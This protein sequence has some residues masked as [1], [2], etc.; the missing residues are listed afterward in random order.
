M[1]AAPGRPPAD[2]GNDRKSETDNNTRNGDRC[3]VVEMLKIGPGYSRGVDLQD[4]IVF[5]FKWGQLLG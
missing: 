3:L 5:P 1:N 4:A 2:V